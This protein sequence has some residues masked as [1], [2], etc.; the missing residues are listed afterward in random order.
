MKFNTLDDIKDA[1]FSGFKTVMELIN[2]NSLIPTVRG[3]YFVLHTQQKKPGFLPIGT[4]G[5][6]KEKDPNVSIAELESNWVE[7]TAV[8]YIGKAGGGKSKATLRS[9]LNQYLQF[10][11]GAK[12]GHWG[13]R[14]IWQI[15]DAQE[16]VICWKPLPTGDPELLEKELIQKFQSIYSKRPLANLRG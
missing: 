9:R 11:Q 12:V 1:G 2:N 16:L 7:N 13:G 4:G 10:G 15:I 5:F 3:V 8:I 6:F 14:L